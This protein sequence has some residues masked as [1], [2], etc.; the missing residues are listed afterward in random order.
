MSAKGTVSID[1]TDFTATA[2]GNVGEF[3]VT[4]GSKVNFS[5]VNNGLNDWAGKG[6]LNAGTMTIDNSDLTI[7]NKTV[8]LE[9]YNVGT[10]S[11]TNGATLTLDR[12]DNAQ[13][14]NLTGGG[15]INTTFAD[16]TGSITIDAASKLVVNDYF[17]NDG[18]ITI[19]AANFAGG[20]QK[21]IDLNIE[22]S[23]KGSAVYF[24]KGIHID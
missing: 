1:N 18:T 16:Q 17:N 20:I 22:N 12:F 14:N 3:N 8:S 10:I 9:F 21:V 24:F 2:F 11:L 6:S 13:A 7:V 5:L 23:L 15:N 4:N 19:D